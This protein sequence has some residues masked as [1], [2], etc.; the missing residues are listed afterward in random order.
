MKITLYFFPRIL[1]QVSYVFPV[2]YL[3]NRPWSRV[4]PGRIFFI[5]QVYGSS[6]VPGPG[7]RSQVPGARC[8]EPGARSWCQEPGDR[9]CLC[10]FRGARSW[11]QEPGDRSWCQEPGARSWGQEPGARSCLCLFR[12][13]R[14]QVRKRCQVRVFL[15]RDASSSARSLPLQSGH[16]WKLGG[17][18]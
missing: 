17:G 12:G 1:S 6:E 3:A 11:C 4:D 10:L 14:C 9:S 15:L 8:Q 13:A 18:D 2:Q 7:A 16:N 5:C